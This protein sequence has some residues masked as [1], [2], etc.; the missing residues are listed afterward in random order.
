[1][2][3]IKKLLAVSMLALCSVNYSIVNASEHDHSFEG[4]RCSCGAYSFE[5]EDGLI[6]GT[7]SDSEQGFVLERNSSNSRPTSEG[8]CVGN[9]SINGNSI[10]WKFALDKASTSLMHLFYAPGSENAVESNNAFSLKVNGKDI[11]FST[12]QTAPRPQDHWYEWSELITNETNFVQGNNIIVL[13][14]IGYSANIDNLVVDFSSDVNI[15][16]Y[17][18][19][20]TKDYKVEAESCDAIVGTPT[21]DNPS[22]ICLNSSCSGGGLIG[23]WGNGDDLATW[24]VNS[25]EEV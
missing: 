22:L 11:S 7:C 1:M 21:Y 19:V 10:T 4:H 9:W 6:G 15:S 25:S 24:Y 12:T 8:K 3:H 18:E 20:I 13:Q 14:N 16:S 17:E 5:A 2:K 23:N